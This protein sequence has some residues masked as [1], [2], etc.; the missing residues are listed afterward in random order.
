MEELM[1]RVIDGKRTA[2]EIQGLFQNSSN[3]L[4]G[5]MP[6]IE[7]ACVLAWYKSGRC[8]SG[9]HNRPGLKDWLEQATGF[10][11]ELDGYD[12][13]LHDW[14]VATLAGLRNS[15]LLFCLDK[16][17]KEE[18]LVEDT[19]RAIH[20][21]SAVNLQ[22][23]LP[24]LEGKRVLVVSP[25][26]ESIRTQWEKRRELF[27]TGHIPIEYPEF[28]LQVVKAHNTIKGNVPFPHL[29]WKESFLD[30]CAQIDQR[31][32]DVAILG[33]GGYGMPLA[34]H[35]KLTGRSAFYVGSYAQVLFGIKGRRWD[36]RVNTVRSYWNEHWK[37]PEKSE[38][39]L[40]Y[41]EVE[42]G[43]YWMREANPL[44]LGSW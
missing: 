33:C 38:I 13:V 16:Q 10:Y 23:W 2:S 11:S 15:D 7:A 30:L 43:C 18:A 6:G 31:S 29:N 27:K 1:E 42:G 37:A 17:L 40:T 9:I 44:R 41:M 5:R 28:D 3:F 34:N 25:F 14:C 36:H 20:V 12:E 21:W 19:L 22:S 35:I 4:I 39:P 24:L 32:F 8:V 26:E